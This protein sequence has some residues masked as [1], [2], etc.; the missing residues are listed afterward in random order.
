MLEEDNEGLSFQ[1][2]AGQMAAGR[3]SQAQWTASWLRWKCSRQ[4]WN[5]AG[6]RVLRAGMGLTFW[7]YRDVVSEALAA[8]TPAGQLVIPRKQCC[9]REGGDTAGPRVVCV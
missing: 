4:G 7:G 9:G 6:P 3:A 1:E 2:L 8:R 5:P